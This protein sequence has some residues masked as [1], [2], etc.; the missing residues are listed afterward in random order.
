MKKIKYF[1]P[2]LMAMMLLAACGKKE[3]VAET[4]TE[5]IVDTET[6]DETESETETQ[7]LTREQ[8]IELDKK[9]Y[10]ITF[11]E[12]K[13]EVDFDKLKE[14]YIQVVINHYNKHATEN[15]LDESQLEFFGAAYISRCTGFYGMTMDDLKGFLAG[16]TDEEYQS[17]LDIRDYY[18]DPEEIWKNNLFFVF[19]Q[20]IKEGYYDYFMITANAYREDDGSI[21]IFFDETTGLSDGCSGT[22]VDSFAKNYTN[23]ICKYAEINYSDEV[24]R[25]FFREYKENGVVTVTNLFDQ[26]QTT[27]NLKSIIEE[28]YENVVEKEWA[29]RSALVGE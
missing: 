8:Q 13:A 25:S 21:A 5:T 2:V 11:E 6:D 14:E 4:R 19:R 18:Y 1:V 16:Y 10:D 15:P 27:A 7:E 22:E 24:L 3:Q 12:L 20:T 28:M 29:E 26:S 9:K 23:L 17:M